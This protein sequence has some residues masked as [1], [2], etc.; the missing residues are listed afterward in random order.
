MNGFI[1]LG[2]P[3][4]NRQ[5]LESA[6][7][8]HSKRPISWAPNVPRPLICHVLSNLVVPITHLPYHVPP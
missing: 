2:L 4:S 6:I 8:V 1:D 3:Y 7:G 5:S